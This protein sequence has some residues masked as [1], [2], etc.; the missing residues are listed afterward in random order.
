MKKRI[1]KKRAKRFMDLYT[2]EK[3]PLAFSDENQRRAYV[4]AWART[5]VGQKAKFPDEAGIMYPFE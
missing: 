1:L 5:Y 4:I 2:K 3:I